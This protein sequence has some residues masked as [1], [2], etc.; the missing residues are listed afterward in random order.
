VK[1]SDQTN[2][3]NDAT[4][5]ACDPDDDNDGVT[6]EVEEEV[7]SNSTKADTDGD[8]VEDADDAYPTDASRSVISVSPPVPVVGTK[9]SVSSGSER[10]EGTVTQTETTPVSE[11]VSVVSKETVE[12]TDLRFSPHSVF[13]YA[14]L[15]WNRFSFAP[16][17]PALESQQFTWDF[18]D[19]VVSQRVAVEHTYQRPGS[20]VV[21]LKVS[22]ADGTSSS[23]SVALSVPFFSLKNRLVVTAVAGLTGLALIGVWLAWRVGRTSRKLGTNED[24]A[25]EDRVHEEEGDD[26]VA[27]PLVYRPESPHKL[28]VRS[29]DS[30]E[31]D[32]E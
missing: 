1:N 28:I 23:E 9:P 31:T 17:A 29:L 27:P 11:P 30:Q 6:D 32:E 12:S 21:I 7:G 25:L 2:S 19:G 3:D 8:G 4:G 24:D 16:I 5:D 10:E 18:G 15:D 13:T 22:N 14:R 26:D 20:Y